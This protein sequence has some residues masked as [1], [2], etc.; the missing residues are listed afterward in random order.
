MATTTKI[1]RTAVSDGT[2][3][4]GRFARLG[5]GTAASVAVTLDVDSGR[6]DGTVNQRGGP[7]C[8][9]IDTTHWLMLV[10]TG[11]VGTGGT[12]PGWAVY[13]CVGTETQ[14]GSG[15]FPSA[16]A[17][18]MMP[19]TLAVSGTGICYIY[20]NGE[21]VKTLPPDA[22]LATGGALESGGFGAYDAYTSASALTRNYDNFGAWVPN[23]DAAMFSGQSAYLRSDGNYRE[24]SDG[25]SIGPI[26]DPTGDLLR[27]PVSGE[28]GR[29]VQMMVKASRGDF[30]QLP[31]SAID[32]ISAR[33]SYRPSWLFVPGS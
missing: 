17:G 7:F 19:L 1:Q 6:I 22:N 29:S 27:I 28:E 33:I 32:D 15:S 4:T 10:R 14:L 21:L 20:I 25:L 3:Q 5:S 18:L 30:D 9:Y 2:L 11:W 8:R 16:N 12:V 24:S 26:A 23:S 13:K 31:D